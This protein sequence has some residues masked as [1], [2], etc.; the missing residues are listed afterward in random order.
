MRKIVKKRIVAN[1]IL[2]GTLATLLAG[3]GDGEEVASL[4]TQVAT[5]TAQPLLSEAES[6]IVNYEYKY[7]S[8]EFTQ[9]DYRALASLY[10]ETG[11]I[12]RQR[13]M[14]EQ[15]YRLNG[16]EESFE[17]LQTITVNLIE[18][19]ADILR[20]AEAMLNNLEVQESR[21][22][23]VNN[24]ISDFWFDTMM[25][26]L[27]KGKRSYYLQK[28]EDVALAIEVGYD[29]SGLP[30]SLL[31]YTGENDAVI[32]LQQKGNTLQWLETTM[33]DGS[34]KG[35]FEAWILDKAAGTIVK[36]EGTYTKG[37]YTGKYTSQMCAD[38]QD[39]DLF[40][41]WNNREGMEY[42]K[43]AGEFDA[44]GKT[45]LEQPDEKNLSALIEGSQYAGCVV[46]A[47]DEE[48]KNCLFKG[49]EE[50][51]EPLSHSF[52]MSHMGWEQYPAFTAYET[53]EDVPGGIYTT[54]FAVTE[55]QDSLQIRIFD[56]EIQY[57]NG[58]NWV[59]AGKA[60]ALSKQDPFYSYAS[61]RDKQLE[62]IW[63]ANKI[64][65]SGE[66]GEGTVGDDKENSSGING[67]LGTGSL[68]EPTPEP[69][70]TPAPTPKP[71]V[72]KPAATPKPTPAPTPTPT[73]T[74]EPEPEEDD[75]DEDDW[76][77][78]PEPEPEPEPAPEP[79]PEP[80]GGDTDIEWSDDIL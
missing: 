55:G 60:A 66:S 68:A 19:D 15:N 45:V 25:P 67:S 37:I 27:D 8:G 12:R 57:Y 72:S 53:V 28:N 9:E 31:W 58:V 80:E 48:Q 24:V 51:V 77:P 41:M 13:D 29:D 73:P 20:E 49:L 10:Q 14:L 75:E 78:A 1:L 36:E 56:G 33:V 61:Q 22:E 76:Q 65:T 3:C 34:Y 70:P 79:A 35:A 32:N 23:A 17:I 46:Y 74:P 18:E 52:D 38:L 6:A 44:E 40:S 5:V 50:G 39:S 69:T 62:E 43:Y 54:T 64:E 26:K 4:V 47:Y 63:V 21:D 30:Y 16:D 7:N 11:R 2:I 59:A 71:V 42:I